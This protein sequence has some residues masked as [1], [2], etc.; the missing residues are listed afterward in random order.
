MARPRS[1]IAPRILHAARARFLED[2]VEGASLRR[3]A[4]EAGTSIGMVYYYH[5]TKDDLFLAVVEEVYAV[6]LEE[7]AASLSPEVTAEE[8]I[9][10]LVGRFGRMSAD[11]FDI[12][13]LIVRELLVASPRVDKLVERFARGHIPLILGTLRDGMMSGELSTAHHPAVMAVA[14]LALAIFPHVV[15]RAIGDRVPPGFDP[16]KGEELAA[17][18]ADVLLAGLRPRPG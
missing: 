8:R 14:T 15:R 4:K 5:P 10:R 11:E 2:G 13:R 17:G 9:R 7:I 3:I 1:D 18:L 12:L 16:P 6:L